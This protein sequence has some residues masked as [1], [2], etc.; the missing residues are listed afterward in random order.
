M[1]KHSSYFE[2]GVQSI[3]FE[4]HGRRLT[5]GVIDRGEYHFTTDAP[6]RMSVTAG[7]LFVR[8]K[9][10]SEFVRYP[11]G[12]RFEIAAKTGFDIRAVEPRSYLCEFL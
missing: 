2:G 12:T 8:R 6:E 7:E 1:L 5:S 9:G 4:R 10:E 3:G 11:A